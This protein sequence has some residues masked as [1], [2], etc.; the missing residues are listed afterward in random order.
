MK[1]IISKK[2]YDQMLRELIEKQDRIDSQEK[3]ITHLRDL[4]RIQREFQSENEASNKRNKIQK[5][6]LKEFEPKVDPATNFQLDQIK[7]IIYQFFQSVRGD[8]FEG[9]KIDIFLRKFIYD[10]KLKIAIVKTDEL[11][12]TLP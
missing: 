9:D 3:S 2:K 7:R 4:M 11:D 5:E 1:V 6:S 12:K 10:D 8:R